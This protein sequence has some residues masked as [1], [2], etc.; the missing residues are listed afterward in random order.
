MKVQLSH[1]TK[2][3]KNCTRKWEIVQSLSNKKLLVV[4]V[5]VVF[6]PHAHT[7]L[8]VWTMKILCDK[9]IHNFVVRRITTA[10]LQPP[11]AIHQCQIR[12]FG[13][14]RYRV[15]LFSQIRPIH[16]SL[17]DPDTIIASL[18]SSR[19]PCS[20]HWHIAKR[21][22]NFDTPSSNNRSI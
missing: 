6:A 13:Y 5:I 2:Y 14:I 8:G 21:L 22:P 1:S 3:T 19:F 4:A 20:F 9:N 18:V 12:R 10:L 11:A 16:Y 17:L 7:W 15:V